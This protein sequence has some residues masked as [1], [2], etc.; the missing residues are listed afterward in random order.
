LPQK[1]DEQKKRRQKLFT[2]SIRRWIW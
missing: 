1:P 2:K